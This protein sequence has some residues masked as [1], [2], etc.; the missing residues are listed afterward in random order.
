MNGL[1]LAKPSTIWTTLDA[2]PQ[3]RA[4]DENNELNAPAAQPPGNEN[5]VSANLQQPS[6][7]TQRDSDN[8]SAGAYDGCNGDTEAGRGGFFG[9]FG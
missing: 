5:E 3:S 2:D 1:S 6:S 7:G 9:F 4:L 8:A